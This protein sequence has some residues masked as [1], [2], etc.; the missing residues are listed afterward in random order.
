MRGLE[1]GLTTPD[2]LVAFVY[3]D[4]DERLWPLAKRSL[5]AGLEKLSEEGRLPEIA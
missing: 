5:A 1:R 4:T 3:A 2:E